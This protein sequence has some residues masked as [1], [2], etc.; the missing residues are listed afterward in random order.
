MDIL[1]DNDVRASGNSSVLVESIDSL[2]GADGVP[3]DE[4]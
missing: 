3:T 4:S 1:K 2:G